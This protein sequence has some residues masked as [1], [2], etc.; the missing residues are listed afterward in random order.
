[1]INLLIVE[2]PTKAKTIK[3]FLPEGFEVMASMGHI[4]DLPRSAAEIPPETK[5]QPWAQIGVNFM[6]DF[7]PIY[8]I[9]EEKKKVVSS[10]KKLV[11]SAD[12]IFL[13][14]DVDREGESISWHLCEV[15]GIKKNVKRMVFHEITKDAISKAIENCRDI[16]YNLV[17]AQE[18][19]R[20]LDRLVGY[21]VSPLLWKKV[22]LGLSAGRVQSAAVKLIVDRERQRIKF[23][24]SEY[25]GL[26]ADLMT[27]DSQ[28]FAELISIDNKRLATGKNFDENTGKLKS[29]AKVVVLDRNK[30]ENLKSELLGKDFKVSDIETKNL[31]K[32]PYPP[33][34]TSTL[35]QE[36]N[37]KLRMTSKQTMR[38]AQ[39]LYEKG[40]ITY[41]RTDS[42]SIA[43]EAVTQIRQIVSSL[44]GQNYLNPKS[45]V[46]QTKAKN[47]Q[48][49]HEAIRPA[50]NFVQP[51]KSGLS[52][53]E[54]ELYSMIWKR[55]L[56]T[57]CAPAKINYIVAYLDVE[58]KLF[59][60]S[61]K[62]I[63]FP[64]YMKVYI[65]D[66]DNDE[67][68]DDTESYL[69]A[70]KK[71]ESIKSSGIDATQHFTQSPPRFTESSIIKA[72]E[73]ESIGRPSTYASI[74]STIQ[75]RKYVFK[76]KTSL[77][78]TFTAFGVTE[79]LEENFPSLVNVKFTAS[80]EE[81][82]DEIANGQKEYKSYLH[83][84]YH[85]EQGLMNQTKEKTESIPPI[86]YKNLKLLDIKDRIC[87]GKFG[88]FIERDVDEGKIQV[89]VPTD[90]APA[91]LVQEKINEL[92]EM[93]K[94]GGNA[95]GVHPVTHE[96]V[97]VL[98]GRYGPFVQLG[99][100]EEDKKIKRVPLLKSMNISEVTID[101]ALKLLALPVKLGKH[102]DKGGEIILSVGRFGPYVCHNKED[103]TKDYRSVKE[104]QVMTI[105]LEQA[106]EAL[107][108]E[109]TKRGSS[110]IREVGEHPES[111]KKIGLYNGPYGAYIKCGTSNY[112][113][114][115]SVSSE[116]LTLE[117]A[118]EIINSK[119]EKKGKTTKAKTTTKSAKA[120]SAKTSKTATA[121]KTKAVTAKAAK[122]V[123]KP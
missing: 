108:V 106:L 16:N 8:I 121:T 45:R 26:K 51:E 2:S 7:K 13:A 76:N 40:L 31:E 92:F 65:E 122:L 58:G 56:A 10:L 96:N 110:L 36:S 102:P 43:N 78:P 61:G 115:K 54:L 98:N 47:A 34:T 19:R 30:A 24:Q 109:K 1:M 80:M 53:K 35:Q 84:F 17:H 18:T 123:K 66:I 85:G 79:L 55:T 28:F 117:E 33:F 12:K 57:Q 69:P 101:Q 119:P 71:G 116:T 97:Y 32:H 4:R 23:V 111:N 20:I 22:A 9:P 3:K 49:A 42:V 91:D 50:G 21:T 64:G 103:N 63:E 99:E 27:K 6:D 104:D 52:N 11:K 94:N 77:C 75:D 60:A 39:A 72:L 59:R 118:I 107:S 70:L 81:I 114:G 62:K 105:N 68:R 88:P 83:S 38:S 25:W 82:L 112:A 113:L 29:A 5:G 46:F 89:S 100:P 90:I 67:E 44:Y 73:Q 120:T 48:E 74:I 93:K 15:L 41:M 87:L 37:R 95:L 86:K 14:T